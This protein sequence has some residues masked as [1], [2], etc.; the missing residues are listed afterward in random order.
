MKVIGLSQRILYHKGRA[1]DSIEHGWYSYLK[2]DMLFFIQNNLDQDFDKLADMIDVLILTGGD[3]SA[4]RRT[5]ET[6]LASKVMQRNK[7]V[8][9][10][11]HGALLLTDLMGGFV[12]ETMCHNDVLH[13]VYY[14]GEERT[15]NSHHSLAIRKLHTTGT[16][17]VVD[18]EGNCEAWI[19]KKL[20]GVM[21]HPER[22]L[23]PWMPDEIQD[24]IWRN[25]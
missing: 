20:A 24:L 4:L 13:Q 23:H 19:D 25:E 10:I 16:E 22:M 12:E 1:Y 11:C 9:G 2:G 18:T 6:K 8:I 21:W 17:L 14:F 3:D 7:P 15:V 5:V